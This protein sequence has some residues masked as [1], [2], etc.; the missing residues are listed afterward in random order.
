MQLSHLLGHLLDS[1]GISW[2]STRHHSRDL[3]YHTILGR[4][5]CRGHLGAPLQRAVAAL[6]AAN[7]QGFWD[8]VPPKSKKHW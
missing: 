3:P 8:R 1:Q 7:H 2:N 5:F 6:L 4:V